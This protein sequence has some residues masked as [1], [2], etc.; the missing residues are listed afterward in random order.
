MTVV[1]LVLYVIGALQTL[2]AVD[3]RRRAEAPSAFGAFEWAQ[4]VVKVIFW[5]LIAPMEL[6]MW[7][8]ERGES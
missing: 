3:D 2:A 8:R 5:W 1:A 6:L 7:A 4:V